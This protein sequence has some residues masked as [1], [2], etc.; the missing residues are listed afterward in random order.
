MRLIETSFCDL[1]CK[2]VVNVIDGRRLGRIIDMVIEER[3]GRVLGI[4]VPNPKRSFS[5]FKPFED[6]FIPYHNICKIGADVILVELF[7]GAVRS[8]DISET[9]QIAN[10]QEKGCEEGDCTTYSGKVY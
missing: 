3:R 4:V 10:T 2:E 6:I 7:C 1:R 9:A 5:L 8:C